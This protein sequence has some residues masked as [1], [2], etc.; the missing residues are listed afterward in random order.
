[1]QCVVRAKLNLY[2]EFV[3]SMKWAMTQINPNKWSLINQPGLHWNRPCTTR[4]QTNAHFNDVYVCMYIH[5]HVSHTHICKCKWACTS[6]PDAVLY[7]MKETSIQN[8]LK[9]TFYC[10]CGRMQMWMLVCV[11]GDVYLDV[12]EYVYICIC[13]WWLCMCTCITPSLDV[14]VVNIVWSRLYSGLSEL[15]LY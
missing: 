5:V 3:L 2:F 15:K 1:M 12:K 9:S 4:G 14:V 7:L 13:M 11:Y 10:T 6:S 8:N